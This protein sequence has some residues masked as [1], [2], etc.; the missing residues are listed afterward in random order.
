MYV[1]APIADKFRAVAL[2]TTRAFDNQ[3]TEHGR[4]LRLVTVAADVHMR[5]SEDPIR[6]GDFG[7]S[8]H[9]PGRGIWARDANGD[10]DVEGA[11][12]VKGGPWRE[13]GTTT[14][15]TLN[16]TNPL[17]GKRDAKMS[18]ASAATRLYQRSWTPLVLG[19]AYSLHVSHKQSAALSTVDAAIR[20]FNGTL[21]RW[22][23]GAAT[24]SDTE[25]WTTLADAVVLT[26]TLIQFQPEGAAVHEILFRP[27][28]AAAQTCQFDNVYIAEDALVTDPLV[29]HGGDAPVYKAEG[30]GRFGFIKGATTGTID[31]AEV[32]AA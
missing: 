8:E 3:I 2:T 11:T 22:R 21:H 17:R 18:L 9:F 5:W 27:T 25:T 7:D 4:L 23:T 12:L 28:G 19:R 13:G 30:E 31:I 32:G 6:G 1:K 29:D 15:I 16:K 14:A 24:W 10:F 26:E 20:W